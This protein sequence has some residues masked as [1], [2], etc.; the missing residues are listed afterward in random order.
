VRSLNFKSTPQAADLRGF[1]VAFMCNS[2]D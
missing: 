2:P 1:F